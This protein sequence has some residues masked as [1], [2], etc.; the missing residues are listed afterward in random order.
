MRLD[1]YNNECTVYAEGIPY[2]ATEE[3]VQK[4]FEKCGTITSLR[5][6]RFQDSGRAR[7]YAHVEFSTKEAATNA[8]KL[9]GTR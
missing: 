6:P 4:F 7:G 3:D 2:T 5:F 8:I 9:N 1:R